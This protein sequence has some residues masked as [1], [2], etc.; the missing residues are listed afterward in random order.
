MMYNLV[1]AYYKLYLKSNASCTYFRYLKGMRLSR[2]Y[3][4]IKKML[5]AA[6][7]IAAASAIV[8]AVC[9][10]Y[11]FYSFKNSMGIACEGVRFKSWGASCV[12]ASLSTKTPYGRAL[13]RAGE[14][15]IRI[16]RDSRSLLGIGL[17]LEA[18][19]PVFYLVN[20]KDD[21]P[22]L[23]KA[24]KPVFNVP[25]LPFNTDIILKNAS[26][27]NAAQV[28]FDDLDA[29]LQL[30]AGWASCSVKA[31]G[32]LIKQFCMEGAAGH[33]L[34]MSQTSFSLPE[35]S[36]EI[37]NYAIPED[38]KPVIDVKQGSARVAIIQGGAYVRTVIDIENA[39]GLVVKDVPF[40]NGKG[41]VTLKND[42][43]SSFDIEL[44]EL[45]SP[46]NPGRIRVRGSS[47]SKGLSY[48]Y[49]CDGAHV[50]ESKLKILG[51]AEIKAA[52][53]AV[54]RSSGTIAEDP[55]S[56]AVC[57]F[58]A[59]QADILAGPL[60]ISGAVVHG[61]YAAG[62]LFINS[63]DGTLYGGKIN[64]RYNCFMVDKSSVETVDVSIIKADLAGVAE[65][66]G[67]QLGL[68]EGVFSMVVA[69]TITDRSK[70]RLKGSF[71]IKKP[72][73]SSGMFLSR[74]FEVFS[75]RDGISSIKC[76]FECRE[77]LFVI[78][79]L[80]IKGHSL[81]FIGS[82]TYDFSAD[83]L[84]IGLTTTVTN[85]KI[86]VVNIITGVAGNIIGGFINQVVAASVTGSL[87]NPELK[88]VPLPAISNKIFPLFSSSESDKKTVK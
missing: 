82:G 86:P 56:Q 61:V 85:N 11:L 7:A 32:P 88:K 41:T 71:V 52:F 74:L 63:L 59:V 57:T 39:S 15:N 54:V 60:Q 18:S 67:K 84:D 47:G 30:Q 58:D 66:L 29:A 31:Q 6:F 22:G 35:L 65:A 79:S 4:R 24:V 77:T 64:G 33:G 49:Q 75:Y 37:L 12:N 9:A 48:D 46:S 26:L 13:A 2:F 40:N 51:M 62:D 53:S 38:L 72:R 5:F 25:A 45:S 83:K 14:L 19:K 23:P 50:D 76:E 44:L 87:A 80:K 8:C 1:L 16:V 10:Y 78:K 68:A 70:A 21:E 3:R 69:G 34:S 43:L 81:N 55:E 36:K 27:K 28:V 42:A 17:R 20:K 73:V